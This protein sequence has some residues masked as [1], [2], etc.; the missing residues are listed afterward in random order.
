MIRSLHPANQ[1]PHPDSHGFLSYLRRHLAAIL[2]LCGMLAVATS[3]AM[4]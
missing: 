1:S 2:V 3:L 4:W